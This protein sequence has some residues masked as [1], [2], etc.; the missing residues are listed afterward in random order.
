MSINE[1]QDSLVACKNKG[2]KAKVKA[3]NKKIR[4]L[5][6]KENAALRDKIGSYAV[7]LMTDL[8]SRASAVDTIVH[9][10]YKN[11]FSI[12]EIGKQSYYIRTGKK[13]MTS[14]SNHAREYYMK[15]TIVNDGDKVKVTVMSYLVDNIGFVSSGVISEPSDLLMKYKNNGAFVN[16]EIFEIMEKVAMQIPHISYSYIK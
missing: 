14:F 9:I 16:D 2:D 4:E 3:I 6:D 7:D 1:L 12:D 11:G 13:N 5:K 15:F 10:L 8:E